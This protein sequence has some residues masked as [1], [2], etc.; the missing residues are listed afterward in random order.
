MNYHLSLYGFLCWIFWEFCSAFF[1]VG[2]KM[3]KDEG[4]IACASS[5]TLRKASK[6]IQTKILKEPEK[7]PQREMG[8]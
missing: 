7:S 1:F 8:K 3:V 2:W 5:C 4:E 6:C